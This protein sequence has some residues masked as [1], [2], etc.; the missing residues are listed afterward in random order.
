MRELQARLAGEILGAAEPARLLV[1]CL[2]AGGHALVEGPPGVGKT[3]IAH[4]LA[5]AI[6]GNFRRVQFTPDLLPSDLVGCNIFDQSKQAFRFLPGP[7]FT[8]LLLADEIN[9]TSPRIQSALLECMNEGQVSV[10]GTTYTIVLPFM[11]VA[12]RNDVFATG[13]FPLPEP[14]LDRFLMSISIALPDPATQVEVLG[15]HLDKPAT[16]HAATPLLQP[17]DVIAWQRR[18]AA[19]PVSAPV[20][21]YIVRLCEAARQ[22]AGHPHA[23][24]VRASLALT[25]AAQAAALFA[26]RVSVHPDDV[27][28]VLPPVFRHRLAPLA[29]DGG[30]EKWLSDIT[31]SVDVP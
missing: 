3:T 17:A 5:R 18:V 13:T 26:G 7:I 27:K 12:T 24:S 16:A 1:L 22:M 20:R 19:H 2:I 30:A 31:D 15:H 4:T 25:K 14:Q 28:S 11:V 9:R 10:D 6:G 29:E 23:L 8:N 21:Q